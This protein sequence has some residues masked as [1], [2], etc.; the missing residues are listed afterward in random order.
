M[1]NRRAIAF[2]PVS[3]FRPPLLWLFIPAFLLVSLAVQAQ[4]NKATILSGQG[5]AQ[6]Q[7]PTFDDASND[8]MSGGF[9]SIINQRRMKMLNNERHKALISDS[10]K[11]LKMVTDLNSEVAHSN[12]GS[13]TPDQLR[14]LAKIEKLARDVRD[15]MTQT[16][17]PPNTSLFPI[18]SPQFNQ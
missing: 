10:D 1:I 18:Y 6:A 13:L 5:A 8:A 2:N 12:P 17:P 11:L 15:K 9:N 14:T 4:T 3:S 16:V 7:R